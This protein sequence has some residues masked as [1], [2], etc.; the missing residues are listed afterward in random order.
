MRY[1]G[2]GMITRVEMAVIVF[3]DHVSYYSFIQEHS[4]HCAVNT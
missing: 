1:G 3:L 2:E 4:P